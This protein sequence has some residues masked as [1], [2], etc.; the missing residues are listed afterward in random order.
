MVIRPMAVAYVM[1]EIGRP[2]NKPGGNGGPAAFFGH[3][4]DIVSLGTGDAKKPGLYSASPLY[5][6]MGAVELMSGDL[7]AGE[8]EFGFFGDHPVLL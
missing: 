5:K 6:I 8:D 7:D 3:A 2:A 4:K 1:G